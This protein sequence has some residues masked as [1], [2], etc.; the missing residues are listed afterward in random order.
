MCDMYSTYRAID[1]APLARREEKGKREKKKKEESKI[2]DKARKG[3]ATRA[4]ESRV[5]LPLSV[6]LEI[7]IERF[8]FASSRRSFL[9]LF[10]FFLLPLFLNPPSRNCPLALPVIF[11]TPRC[12]LSIAERVGV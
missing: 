9:F 6:T 2:T 10:L 4:R 7:L 12:P 5:L 11:F 3:N 8:P 1:C